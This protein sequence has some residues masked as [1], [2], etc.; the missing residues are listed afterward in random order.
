V[1]LED[2]KAAVSACFEDARQSLESR[3][4]SAEGE[5][6][7][8]LIRVLRKLRQR[9][10]PAPSPAFDTSSLENAISRRESCDSDVEKQ[11]AAEDQSISEAIC[12]IVR[13]PLF[14]EAI[15][16]QNLAAYENALSRIA[17]G[18][19]RGRKKYR[20]AEQMVASYLQRYCVKNDTIGFFGPQGSGEIVSGDTWKGRPGRRSLRKRR[21]YLEHW[22]VAELADVISQ[23][24]EVRAHLAPKLFAALRYSD[25]VLHHGY[26]DTSELPHDVAVVISSCTDNR[27][28]K[29]IAQT[30]LA[31][32]TL[33]FDDEEDV[34]ELLE[35]LHDR[36]VLSWSITLPTALNEPELYLERVLRELPKDVA[37]PGLASLA[38]LLEARDRVSQSAGNAEKLVI[39][40]KALNETFEALTQ[41]DATRAAGQMYAGRTLVYEECLRDYELAIGTGALAAVA[42]PLQL[43]LQSARWLTA[44]VARRFQAEWGMAFDSICEETGATCVD[45]MRLWGEIRRHFGS[46]NETSAIVRDV[47]AQLQSRWGAML[48]CASDCRV[49]E[50]DAASLAEEIH[51]VFAASAPGWPSA[52]YHSPDLMVVS[53][54][55][56]DNPGCFVL[57]EIHAAV[58]T[59]GVRVYQSQ[60]NHAEQMTAARE[61]DLPRPSVVPVI[62]RSQA[63]RADHVWMARHNWDLETADTPSWREDTNV[64]AVGNLTVE[65]RDGVLVVCDRHS[66]ATFSLLE[67]LETALSAEVAGDFNFLPHMVHRPRIKIDGLIIGRETWT[68]RPEELAFASMPRGARQFAAVQEWV[69]E[70]ELPPRVFV[71]VPEETKPVYIDLQSP[72]YVELLARLCRQGS[73]IVVS[74]MLPDLEQLWLTD[75]DGRMYTSELRVVALDPVRWEEN[76]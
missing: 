73:T 48:G 35:D 56:D 68:F 71:K 72:L 54:P 5:E 63:T 39:A 29:E 9:K 52:R 34:Y 75:K 57:G 14:R 37:Q 69:R 26:G 43:L 64:L 70:L 41:K 24:E 47:K 51:H 38:T 6:R 11:F 65:R 12:D 67:V 40:L 66:D 23:D 28:A 8:A 10:V 27:S 13:L 42:A 59:C 32:P 19:G 22:A 46:G 30:L 61:V 31:D 2:A 1:R 17:S 15:A 20:R 36:R 50:R 76:I 58:N 3:I 60:V 7:R 44:E 16:W 62:A 53:L 55:E 45:Y 25:G 4:A 18:E 21:V 49:I 33:D 74:E